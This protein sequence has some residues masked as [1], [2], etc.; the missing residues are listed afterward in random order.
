[1][2]SLIYIESSRIARTTQRNPVSE[3]KK[4]KKERNKER[5]KEKNKQQQQ[6][7]PIKQTKPKKGGKK[8]REKGRKETIQ[9][10]LELGEKPDLFSSNQCFLKILNGGKIGPLLFLPFSSWT[11]VASYQGCTVVW[12]CHQCTYVLIRVS[13]AVIK[14]DQ[15]NLG[16]E[17]LIWPTLQYWCLKEVRTGTQ[18]QEL[19]QKPQRGAAYW[20][21][22]H[23]LLILFSYRA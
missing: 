5:D 16:R 15:R 1:M 9:W 18:R 23:S 17:E 12:M 19:M 6:Q 8:E 10:E 2:A 4:G 11:H 7:K 14:H 20:L 3:K 13:I 22:P 21:A